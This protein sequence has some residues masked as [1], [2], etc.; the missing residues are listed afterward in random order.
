MRSKVANNAF[1]YFLSPDCSV[2]PLIKI[3]WN[4]LLQLS[5]SWLFFWL[6]EKGDFWSHEIQSHDHFPISQVQFR[7]NSNQKNA[8]STLIRS[9]PNLTSLN[10]LLVFVFR[11]RS[12][13][14]LHY[15]RSSTSRITSPS[16]SDDYWIQL[17]QSNW[18]R[19]TKFPGLWNS[20][21][22]PG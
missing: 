4:L 20:K 13:S 21:I 8:S 12:L 19:V 18:T 7:F 16:S 2:N 10:E 15:L 17:W 22:R 5:I 11:S 9:C 3:Y 1:S 14:Y 6:P